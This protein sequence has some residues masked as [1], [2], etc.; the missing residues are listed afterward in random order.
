MSATAAQTLPAPASGPS[1]PWDLQL[2][3]VMVSVNYHGEMNVSL[4]RLVS[5][6][7]C[8]YVVTSPEDVRTQQMA[9]D[10]GAEVLI[11]RNFHARRA[12]FNKAEAVLIGQQE[13]HR[14]HPDAWYALVDADIVVPE[15]LRELVMEEALV[16]NALYTMPR[17]DYWTPQ[18]YADKRP[19][20]KYNK[21]GVG[22]FQLYSEATR[23]YASWSQ[24]ASKADIVFR[25]KFKHMYQLSGFVEHLGRK[26]INWD[27]RK[28][29]EWVPVPPSAPDEPSPRHP[30]VPGDTGADDTL[31]DLGGHDDQ[32]PGGNDAQT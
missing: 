14:R 12:T 23:F 32:D 28:S 22:Y 4:P 7:D 17:Y 9:R 18:A 29:E 21:L 10:A 30:R 24:N 31:K 8:V 2:V 11:C 19:D 15:N 25:N 16:S 26:R 5:V 13:A 27:G 1:S 6:C 3:A 20:D